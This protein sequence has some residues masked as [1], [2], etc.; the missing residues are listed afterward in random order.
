[1]FVLFSTL[2]NYK[3]KYNPIVYKL[4]K[5]NAKTSAFLSFIIYLLPVGGINLMHT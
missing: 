4:L 3:T 5:N 1:M 2:Q